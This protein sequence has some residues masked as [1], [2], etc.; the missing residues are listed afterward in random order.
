MAD[1]AMFLGCAAICVV[2]PLGALYL[3][4][5]VAFYRRKRFSLGSWTVAILLPVLAVS[6]VGIFGDRLISDLDAP[7]PLMTAACDGDLDRV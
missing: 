1:G 2:L 3:W 5:V 6:S 4:I 7:S